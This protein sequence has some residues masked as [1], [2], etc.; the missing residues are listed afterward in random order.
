M[1]YA[2]NIATDDMERMYEVSN[3]CVT[4][5]MGKPSGCMDT[6]LVQRRVSYEATVR[7]NPP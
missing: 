2:K 5:A 1:Y 4:A 6:R 3:P 7:G